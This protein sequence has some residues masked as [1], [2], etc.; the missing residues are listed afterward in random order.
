MQTIRFLFVVNASGIPINFNVANLI[1][2]STKYYIDRNRTVSH[3]LCLSTL[4]FSILKAVKVDIHRRN[5][6]IGRTQ[7]W[8]S[9][10]ANEVKV[11]HIP[12]KKS[13]AIFS[14]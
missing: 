5:S 14:T 13:C 4:G 9:E 12:T 6:A 2:S 10:M 7:S 8:P 11:G 3:M 1:L